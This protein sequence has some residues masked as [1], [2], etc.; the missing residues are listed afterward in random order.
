M[1]LE[2]ETERLNSYPAEVFKLSKL[3]CDTL[4]LTMSYLLNL[5]TYLGASIRMPETIRDSG[6]KGPHVHASWAS[7]GSYTKSILFEVLGMHQENT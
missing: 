4:P 1:N 2:H 3:T 5:S 7:Q 6:F